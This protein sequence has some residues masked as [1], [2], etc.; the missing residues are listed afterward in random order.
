[1]GKLKR[2]NLLTCFHFAFLELLKHTR[3]TLVRGV[4]RTKLN[5]YDGAFSAEIV[6]GLNLFLHKSSIV[7]VRRGSKYA[8]DNN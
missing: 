7:D 8:S 5:I 4:C 3:M 1:M 2:F 6:N